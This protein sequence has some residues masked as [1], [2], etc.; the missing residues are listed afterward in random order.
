MNCGGQ[1]L[2]WRLQ[3][4]CLVQDWPS[5]QVWMQ[6]HL[7]KVNGSVNMANRV[8]PSTYSIA[9]VLN[10]TG[11]T[12]SEFVKFMPDTNPQKR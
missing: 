3:K 7:I 9:K 12:M 4:I 8:G 10:A 1:L 5:L 6:Q 11:I 2:N